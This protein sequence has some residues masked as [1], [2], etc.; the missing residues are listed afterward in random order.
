MKS[1]K[2]DYKSSPR[3]I[4]KCFF[5]IAAALL[6]FVFMPSTAYAVSIVGQDQAFISVSGEAAVHLEPDVAYLFLGV[7]TQYDSPLRAQERNSAI[8]ADVIAAIRAL[9]VDESDIQTTRFNMFPVQHW[10]EVGGPQTVGYMVS[11][12]ISVTVRDIDNV[13]AVLGAATGAGANAASSVS[14]GLQDGGSAYSQALALAVEDATEKARTIAQALGRNLGNV[15][16]VNE[17]SQMGIRPFPV[18]RAEMGFASSW[19]MAGAGVPVQGGELAIT[20]HVQ[21]TFA[22]AP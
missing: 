15:I 9:G 11:N 1:S 4:S 10:T 7:D 16:S 6:V 18:A 2:F 17:F 8:M 12:H 22:I 14:F 5:V 21:I 13:G 20:A 3:F 19:D